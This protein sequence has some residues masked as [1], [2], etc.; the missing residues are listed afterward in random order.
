M[1][2]ILNQLREMRIYIKETAFDYETRFII[3]H[4]RKNVID[5]ESSS[6]QNV[7]DELLPEPLPSAIIRSHSQKQVNDR[8]SSL[9]FY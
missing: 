9:N 3:Q 4:N 2:R 1:E 6:S 5:L 7:G 8:H